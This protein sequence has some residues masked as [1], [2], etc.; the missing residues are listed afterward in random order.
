MD[1]M[2]LSGSP[3]TPIHRE[4][5]EVQTLAKSANASAM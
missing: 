3:S 4:A 5:G 1:Q 2:V